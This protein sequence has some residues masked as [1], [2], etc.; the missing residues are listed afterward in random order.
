MAMLPILAIILWISIA[1]VVFSPILV[2]TIPLAIFNSDNAWYA[3][4]SP[5]NRYAS[6]IC[7]MPIYR[8]FCPS[9]CKFDAG[10]FIY[11]SVCKNL[12]Y[13]PV[14]A[15]AIEIQV[16]AQ[17]LSNVAS[18]IESKFYVI[19]T[20]IQIFRGSIEHLIFKYQRHK[21]PLIESIDPGYFDKVNANFELFLRLSQHSPRK[22]HRLLRTINVTIVAVGTA[23]DATSKVLESK[24]KNPPPGLLRPYLPKWMQSRSSY[25]VYLAGRLQKHIDVTYTSM[26]HLML[27]FHEILNTLDEMLVPLTDVIRLQDEIWD[28]IGEAKHQ[29]W[30]CGGPILWAIQRIFG[31]GDLEGFVDIKNDL[32]LLKDMAVIV[33]SFRDSLE[34]IVE[35]CTKGEEA[36]K[37]MEQLTRLGV[38]WFEW[39]AGLISVS[40]AWP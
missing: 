12:S 20:R 15:A 27:D 28:A 35:D 38:D 13:R 37:H 8:P 32:Q 16:V 30:R 29:L 17:K 31:F 18:A 34:L 22:F 36:A 14:S 19:P 6:K 7:T 3:S 25:L 40:R 10:E 26:D 5:I 1:L 21:N 23:H 9:I 2:L 33:L 24:P 39:G 4:S 11:P